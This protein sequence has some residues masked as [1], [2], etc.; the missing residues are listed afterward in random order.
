MKQEG[1]PK[2]DEARGGTREMPQERG[3]ALGVEWPPQPVDWKPRP[4]E[5]GDLGH[6]HPE[7]GE[8]TLQ[9]STKVLGGPH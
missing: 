8:S 9:V 5:G 6:C 3:R 4:C 2:V 7:L 1:I